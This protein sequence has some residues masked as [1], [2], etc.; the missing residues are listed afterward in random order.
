MKN[1]LPVNH[2]AS[3]D[4]VPALSD[5]IR[6]PFAL[7]EDM[8]IRIVSVTPFFHAPDDTDRQILT[9]VARYGC[10]TIPLLA[11]AMAQSGH[12]FAD[13]GE[14]AGL[15]RTLTGAGF[16]MCCTVRARDQETRKSIY[17][18]GYKGN[19]YIRAMHPDL[20]RV[21][22]STLSPDRLYRMLA[23]NQYLIRTGRTQDHGQIA[24]SLILRSG[25]VSF[26]STV[27]FRP[28]CTVLVDAVR[29][30]VDGTDAARDL[31]DKLARVKAVLAGGNSRY[32]I[33]D[34]QLVLVCEDVAHMRETMR[35]CEKMGRA[36]IPIAF[37]CDSLTHACPWDC[38]WGLEPRKPFLTRLFGTMDIVA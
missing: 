4:L 33:T 15:V 5:E 30:S 25:D 34:P 24:S 18:L 17:G 31:M 13:V 6:S 8:T 3:A 35:L 2:V 23:V 38:L 12:R 21:N 22:I 1:M 27:S 19:G 11:D 9:C 14:V 16:L 28:D 7:A 36:N 32:Q 10:L 29:R 20:H 26:R 37:T